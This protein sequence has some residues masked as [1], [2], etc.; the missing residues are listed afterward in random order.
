LP[1]CGVA[2]L[3]PTASSHPP[4]VASAQAETAELKAVAVQPTTVAQSTAAN[5]YVIGPFEQ[6]D[7]GVRTY[8]IVRH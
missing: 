3:P 5:H 4:K 1:A 6:G 7:S 8:Y 2:A